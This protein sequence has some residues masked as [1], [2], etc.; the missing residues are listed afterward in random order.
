MTPTVRLREIAP[1]DLDAFFQNEQDPRAIQMAA[2][3]AENPADREAFLDRWDRIF[4]D[5]NTT[6]D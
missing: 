4:A 6:N 5:G 2:F 3:T 1:D